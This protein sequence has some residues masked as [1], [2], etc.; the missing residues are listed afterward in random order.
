MTDRNG[1]PPL[2][3]EE[4]AQFRQDH[5]M[6][7]DALIALAAWVN[8]RPDQLPKE[9]QAHNCPATMEA[10]G[11]VAQALRAA[12]FEELRSALIELKSDAE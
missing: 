7:A 11:R 9:M 12:W 10:W 8:V 6:K 2:T 5:P 3:K 4:L 1:S